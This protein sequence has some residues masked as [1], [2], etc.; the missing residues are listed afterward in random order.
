MSTFPNDSHLLPEVAF[1]F[2]KEVNEDDGIWLE[3]LKIA[4]ESDKRMIDDWTRVVDS[5]LVFVG[6]FF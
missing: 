3:Y 6:S 1:Q 4:D 5:I 2:R